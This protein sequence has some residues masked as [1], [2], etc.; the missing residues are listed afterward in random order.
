MPPC[1]TAVLTGCLLA[2]FADDVTAGCCPEGVVH[3]CKEQIDSVC[4]PRLSDTP[5]RLQFVGN[6]TAGAFK[7]NVKFMLS[8]VAL[9]EPLGEPDCRGTDVKE[10][11]VGGVLVSPQCVEV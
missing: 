5:F 9:G 1:K 3:L 7:T 4:N 8:S 6:G 2:L 11:G 10:V